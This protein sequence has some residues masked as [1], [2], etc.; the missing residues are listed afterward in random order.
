[1][2][3]SFFDLSP[4]AG[5]AS[6]SCPTV[7]PPPE[8][9]GAVL[10]VRAPTVPGQGV[11]SLRFVARN[12]DVTGHAVVKRGCTVQFPFSDQWE[13]GAWSVKVDR[14]RGGAFWHSGF[15]TP[16]F[17]PCCRVRVIA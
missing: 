2:N 3:Q 17:L 14:V 5:T 6:A 13:R 1:M 16:S 8:F 4:V 9:N 7:C 11:G 10:A 15:S 12:S